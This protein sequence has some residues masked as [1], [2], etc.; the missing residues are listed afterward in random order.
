MSTSG[1]KLPWFTQQ[2]AARLVKA[3][4]NNHAVLLN[5]LQGIGKSHLALLLA[6][7]LFSNSTTAENH[8]LDAGTHPDIHVLTSAFAYQYMDSQLKKFCF[9][10]LD[11]EAVEKKRL[12]RQISINTIRALVESMNEAS[13]SGGNKL[14]IIYP[15]EHL[16]INSANA[17]LKFLEEPTSRTYLILISHDI[18]KLTPTIRS[19]CM[20]INI[21]LPDNNDSTDWLTSMYP[22]KGQSEIVSALEL[23][24][25]RPLLA[26]EYLSRD[27]QSL[28]VALEH[29]IAEI[30]VNRTVNLILIARKWTKYQQTDFILSWLCQFFTSLIKVKLQDAYEHGDMKN[31]KQLKLISRS[32]SSASLFDTYDYL[33]SLNHGYDGIIDEILLIEDVLHTIANNRTSNA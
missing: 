14:A 8:L 30:A 16:N 3:F 27:Q 33:K 25:Y 29:D 15:A 31:S 32:F 26:A 12:S 28:A 22:G 18:S 6:R 13:S 23:A 17:I 21:A 5:G 20:R 9:R 7:N 24:G 2:D 4:D 11:R 19:R 10:Y 1:D